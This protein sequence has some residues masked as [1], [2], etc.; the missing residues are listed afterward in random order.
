MIFLLLGFAC[1]IVVG[2]LIVV[3]IGLLMRAEVNRRRAE[4]AER[5]LRAKEGERP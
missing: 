5:K 2:M 1:L 4:K 3:P